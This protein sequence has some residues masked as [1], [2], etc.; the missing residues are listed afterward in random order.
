MPPCVYDA[1]K[2]HNT[3]ISLYNVLCESCIVCRNDYTGLSQAVELIMLVN[4][5]LHTL[6][7]CVSLSAYYIMVT[8]F[9]LGPRPWHA[10]LLHAVTSIYLHMY[11]CT[12]ER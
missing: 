2:L 9:Y 8:M 1:F 5:C 10:I 12:S 4:T 7:L 6:L 3:L 11:I